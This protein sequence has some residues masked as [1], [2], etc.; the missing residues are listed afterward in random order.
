MAEPPSQGPARATA[1]SSRPL[2]WR[3]PAWAP[4]D[5]TRPA[6]TRKTP[7]IERTPAPQRPSA[8][9]AL[10]LQQA[11]GARAAARQAGGDPDAR[12]GLDPAELD[13]ATGGVGD[14]R[15]GDL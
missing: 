13:D 1:P 5:A 14:Q 4:A 10:D 7:E 8:S 9:D 6:Q 3:A 2:S 15:L 12:A 11:G